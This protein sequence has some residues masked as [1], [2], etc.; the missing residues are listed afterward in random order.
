MILSALVCLQ[1]ASAQEY[2]VISFG[3]KYN[4]IAARINSRVDANGRKSAVVKVYADDKIATVRGA[5]VGEV[6]SIGMGKQIS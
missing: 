1:T 4:D 5:A 6:E 2:E 3:V